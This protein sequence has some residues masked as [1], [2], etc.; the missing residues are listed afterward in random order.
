MQILG[1]GGVAPTEVIG[2]QDLVQPTAL[3]KEGPPTGGPSA[4]RTALAAS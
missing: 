4:V 3:L 1:A 2:D